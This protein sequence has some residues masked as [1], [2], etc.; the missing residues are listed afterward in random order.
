MQLA[1]EP[2]RVADPLL[3]L[4]ALERELQHHWFVWDAWTMGRRR[5][6]LHPFVLSPSAHRAA[7][8]A[9]ERAWTLVADAADRAAADPSEGARYR[10]HPDVDRLAAAAR[11]GGDRGAIARVDLLLAE[12]GRW[13]ACEVNADCPGGYNETLALPRLARSAGAPASFGDPTHVAGSLADTLLRRANGGLVALLYAT[14]YAEDLQVCAILERLLRERGAR[15][16]RCAPTALKPLGDGVGVRGEAVAVAYRFYPLEYMAGQSNIDA[17]VRATAAGKLA[18]MSSF[19]WIHAQSKLAMAR[20]FAHDAAAAREVF[21][22]TREVADL[23]RPRLLLERPDWVLK[24]DLSRVG[25]HVYV[26]ALTTD[27][28]W[29]FIADEIASVEE[30]GDQAWIAQRF[31]RQRPIA[32]PWGDRLVTLGVYLLDGA[33]AGYFARF[34]ATSHCSHEALVLP[35]FVG[36]EP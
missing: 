13:I 11:A 23:S 29:T 2:L 21:P 32:T 17:I 27:E 8:V 12:D 35:V 3:A 24:R 9:A 4:P 6:D 25:D 20:A 22:E 16:V 14:G 19:R 5:V 31:V 15:V 18:S 34:S 36:A 28:E 7:I 1:V 10:F 30:D 33:F 26:G